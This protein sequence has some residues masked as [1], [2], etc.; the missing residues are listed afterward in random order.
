M[1]KIFTLF[2]AV[3]LTASV[4]A[5]SP[6]K[7]SYQAVIRNSSDVLVTNTQVGMQISILQGTANGSP[8]YAETQ[9]PTTN[10]NGLVSFEIGTGT[11]SDDFST[12]DWANGPYYIKTETDPAGSANY[13]ITGTSQLLS[14]PYAL[15]AKTAETVTEAD[16]LF[17]S[18]DKSTG[19]S[20]TES[21]V[22]NLGSYIEVE[23][24]P[25]Y[26][27]SEAANITATDIAN[28][29]NLSGTNTGDQ[30]I[31]GIDENTQ[32]IQDTASQ[33]RSDMPTVP[34]NV[35]SFTN[36]AGYITHFSDS[37]VL[38]AP[39]GIYY[40]LTIQ[41][42]GTIMADSIGLD[43]SVLIDSDGN[44]YQT[45]T[46]GTQVWMTENLKVTKYNDGT[47]IPLVTGSDHLVTP[48]AMF[49]YNDNS[50]S[51]YGALYTYEAASNA[52]PEGWHLPS[53]AEWNEMTYYLSDNG[54]NYDGSTGY[55]DGKI[56]KALAAASGWDL[57]TNAGAVGNT[58]YPEKRNASRLSLL[59]G[60]QRN[61]GGVGTHGYWWS[62]TEEDDMVIHP[63]LYYG[64]SGVHW[65]KGPRWS[66]FS[67]R[68]VK[69]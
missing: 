49:Y 60:G 29:S 4:F 33:I 66:G 34:A 39:N 1:R 28:L 35:S 57:S 56:A 14:V 22:S 43:P 47:D 52:C 30:D 45:V 46:I 53:R 59:P 48:D 32:A 69:D 6:E 44:L 13:T 58:D 10:A 50:N 12:I 5:Q 55:A 18:W 19:I 21:Q 17:T 68:C 23:T 36:D 26:S 42:G 8:V 40:K 20:I 63:H 3:L 37:I 16:P 27:G 41:N 38:K 51:E 61:G 24:D 64:N 25:L 67:V 9:T 65:G 2:A 7:M 31:S 62:S 11:T 54:Y 15:H